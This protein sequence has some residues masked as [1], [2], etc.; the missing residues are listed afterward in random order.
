MVD[1]IWVEEDFR[2]AFGKSGAGSITISK[3]E[4]D[5]L[6]KGQSKGK[7]I[8][9]GED[10]RPA[11]ADQA[12]SDTSVSERGW[13]NSEL[14]RADIELNKVQDSDPKAVG[15]VGQWREYRK[16]LRA[17]PDHTDFPDKLKRPTSPQ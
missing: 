3:Q 5:E 6:L 17:W 9:K 13:R 1:A 16:Q 11:L 7:Q 14:L 10:G 12:R 4:L 8:I 2:W 15:T